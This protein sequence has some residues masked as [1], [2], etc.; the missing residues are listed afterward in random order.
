MDKGLSI[1]NLVSGEAAGQFPF[2]LFCEKELILVI[3]LGMIFFL[4]QGMVTARLIAPWRSELFN[5]I[6]R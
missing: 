6:I 2:S 1:S 3:R 4:L 5:S